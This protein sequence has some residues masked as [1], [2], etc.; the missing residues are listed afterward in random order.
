MTLKELPNTVVHV[1]TQAG[2]DELMQI[3]DD[4][5]W[6]WYFGRKPKGIK[7]WH[8]KKEETCVEVESTFGYARKPFYERM[9]YK[10]ITLQQ[11]KELQGLITLTLGMMR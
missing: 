3:Y 6:R 11:F 2:Y 10:V 8:V 5:W 9:D 4:A 1:P 7:Y